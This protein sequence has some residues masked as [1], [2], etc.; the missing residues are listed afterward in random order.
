MVALHYPFALLVIDVQQGL[1]ARPT[2]IYNEQAFLSNVQSLIGSARQHG[3]LV[4]FVQHCNES[5]LT[6]DTPAW[7]LHAS[8]QPGAGDMHIYKRHGS[9]FE[10]TELETELISRGIQKLVICG[11]VT[12]GCVKA[13][14]LD[15]LKLG[16][17]T[18]LISDAHSS[19][20]KDAAKLIQEWNTKLEQTGAV[21][22]TTAQFIQRE[23]VSQTA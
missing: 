14:C 8:L 7:Q 18:T 5:Y 19:F 15:A 22:L 4:I 1:F 17:Q 13:G 6:K 9:S 20:S 3:A 21:Q 11:L 10:E 23:E 16:Y 2:P 12:H